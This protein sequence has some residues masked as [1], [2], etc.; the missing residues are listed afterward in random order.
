[1]KMMKR[2]LSS[3]ILLCLGVLFGTSPSSITVSA[4]PCITDNE[5]F[6][7]VTYNFYSSQL[8]NPPRLDIYNQIVGAFGNIDDWCFEDPNT[9]DFLSDFS[10]A[11]SGRLPIGVLGEDVS[12]WDTSKAT[13]MDHMFD[14]AIFV[15]PIGIADWNTSSVVSTERM[16]TSGEYVYAPFESIGN[17]DVRKVTNMI[18]MFANTIN[19]SVDLNTWDTESVTTTS[20]MFANSQGFNNEISNWKMDKVTDMS[21]M[22]VQAFAFNQD[23]SN[24][25]VSKVTDMSSMFEFTLAFNGNISTWDM[26]NVRVADSM[27]EI[28]RLFNQ[29]ISAWDVSSM[30]RSSRMFNRATS[31]DQNLCPWRKIMPRKNRYNLYQGFDGTSCSFNTT[32]P[33]YY[34]RGPYCDACVDPTMP[35]YPDSTAPSYST[36]PSLSPTSNAAAATTTTMK[37]IGS[38]ILAVVMAVDML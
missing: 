36:A 28:S 20:L 14:E 22:F 37:M 34:K 10:Y 33:G 21:L 27:F 13:R 26:S 4:Q 16:F 8:T 5:L 31:F 35:V 38:L 3:S 29:D 30:E 18:G 1:M 25:D 23:L 7:S 6:N 32:D 11:F 19:L 15:G 2:S 12:A 9:G 17:W 24:W